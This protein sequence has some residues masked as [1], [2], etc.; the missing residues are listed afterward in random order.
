MKPPGWVALVMFDI[1]SFS[2]SVSLKYSTSAGY[3]YQNGIVRGNNAKKFT[4]R[5]NESASFFED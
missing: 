5:S 1:K 3:L 2:D 4:F